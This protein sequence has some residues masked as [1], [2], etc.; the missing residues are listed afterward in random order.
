MTL[1]LGCPTDRRL[2]R[3]QDEAAVNQLQNL[4]WCLLRP[5]LCDIL[6][7]DCRRKATLTRQGAVLLDRFAVVKALRDWPTAMGAEGRGYDGKR[8][9]TQTHE[10][11]AVVKQR[12]RL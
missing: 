7:Q 5:G 11:T 3:G 2:E 8:S 10:S 6:G 4:L 12:A 1:G 9:S